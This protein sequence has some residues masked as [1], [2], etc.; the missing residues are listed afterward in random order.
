MQQYNFTMPE[1]AIFPKMVVLAINNLCDFE[2]VHCY[3]PHIKQPEYYRQDMEMA[4]FCKIADELKQYPHATLRFLAWGEPLL[5]PHLV[6]FIKYARQVGSKNPLALIT[7]GYWLTP[8]LSFALMEAGLNL[9][10]ISIDAATTETYSQIRKS[11]YHDALKKIEDN[12]KTMINKRDKSG[13]FTRIVV[14]FI[15]HP[16]KESAQEFALFQEK[17][18]DIADEIVKRPAHTFKGIITGTPLPDYRVPCY[19]LWHRCNIT[20]WGQVSVCYQDWESKYILGD[21]RDPDTTIRGIWQSEI[22][23]QLRKKQ[24]QGIFEGIFSD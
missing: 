22:L 8:N 5:H 18:T 11:H 3:Y 13:L 4:I 14:S 17:W 12:V 24:C 20:P 6:E 16:T 2:C 21:L 10:E 23:C 1:E 15:L 9:V 19:G 7:N